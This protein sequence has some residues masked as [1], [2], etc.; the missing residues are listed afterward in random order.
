MKYRLIREFFLISLICLIFNSLYLG[1]FGSSYY[2]FVFLGCLV[3]G[4]GGGPFKHVEA[5]WRIRNSSCFR[6]WDSLS[7]AWAYM[8][9]G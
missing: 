5:S 6:G 2:F 8:S 4:G 1:I 7:F 9:P 3:I